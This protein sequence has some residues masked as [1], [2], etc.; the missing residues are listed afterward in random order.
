VE[1][2]QADI[3]KGKAMDPNVAARYAG[4]GVAVE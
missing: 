2:A 3:N 1:G 4:Y